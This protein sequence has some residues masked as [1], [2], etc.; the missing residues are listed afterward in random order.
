MKVI[1]IKEN[2]Y[3]REKIVADNRVCKQVNEFNYL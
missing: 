3:S 2:E 1:A